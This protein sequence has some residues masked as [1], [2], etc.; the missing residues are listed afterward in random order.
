MKIESLIILEWFLLL[1]F[2]NKQTGDKQTDIQTNK[3]ANKQTSKQTHKQTHIEKQIV[4]V[5][6]RK[7]YNKTVGNW[8]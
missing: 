7:T 4:F 2:V 6:E 5:K 3:G 8:I 1:F